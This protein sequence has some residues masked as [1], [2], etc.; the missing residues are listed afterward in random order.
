[1]DKVIS[2]IHAN[3]NHFS[4]IQDKHRIVSKTDFYVPTLVSYMLLLVLYKLSTLTATTFGL[5]Y[6]V[7]SPINRS[8]SKKYL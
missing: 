3:A 7:E 6:K 8:P 5:F 2:S 1:M 4:S